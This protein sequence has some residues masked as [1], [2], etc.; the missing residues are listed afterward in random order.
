MCESCG[1][2]HAKWSGQCS[3]CKEWSCIKEA[4]N[5]KRIKD[6]EIIFYSIDS[7]VVL[8]EQRVEVD[9]KEFSRVCGGG[10]VKGSVVLIGGAPGIGKSTL[11]MQIANSIRAKTIYISG[12]ESVS[13][14]MLRARRLGVQSKILIAS[15]TKID[16]II[17]SIEKDTQVLIIDSIQTMR[18]SGIDSAAGSVNQIRSTSQLL[19]DF[20]KKNGIICILVGHV[21]KDGN[22]AGP[23]LLEHMVD[24]VFY[25]ESSTNYRLLRATKNRFGSTN[26]VGIF[27]MTSVG[28]SDVENSSTAFIS[29]SGSSRI[30]SCVYSNMDA[31]RSIL[32]EVQSLISHSNFQNPRRSTTGWDSN[33]LHVVLAAVETV[34]KISFANKDVF[35]NIAGGF[36]IF[37]TAAD[38]P[39]IISIF[40]SLRQI[41]VDVD[42]IAFGEIGLSGEVRSVTNQD[43][44]IEE[45]INLGFKKIVLARNSKVSEKN[46][47]KVRFMFVE[48][49]RDVFNLVKTGF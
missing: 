11:L 34:C 12:E 46:K 9:S 37:E 7:D 6:E 19:I 29:E 24:A 40:S 16:L 48:N 36:K 45:A 47:S 4:S 33:R 31:S 28:M 15:E 5:T 1:V 8:D 3:S 27:E 43:K 18:S 13:Q 22:I 2:V 25:L 21:T 23:N 44:R 30:G 10:L 32:M 20:C 14:V 38:L 26:E 35:V 41:P 49:V 17:D 39:V 42:I